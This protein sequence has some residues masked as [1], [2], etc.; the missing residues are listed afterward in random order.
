M[1]VNYFLVLWKQKQLCKHGKYIFITFPTV[2]VNSSRPATV[3]AYEVMLLY[4]D[5]FT[6]NITQASL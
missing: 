6:L 2:Q 3:L 1:C 4:A 5:V